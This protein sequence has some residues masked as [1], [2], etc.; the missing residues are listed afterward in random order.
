MKLAIMQPYFFPYIGYFQLI[1][2]VDKFIFY[3]D[4]NFIKK[5]WINRNNILINDSAFLFSIP[6][7]NI[8]QNKLINEV[9]LFFDS[10]EKER[11]LRRIELAYKKADE[12]D[13]F[14]PVLENFILNDSSVKISELAIN[15][16]ILVCEY[17]KLDVKFEY[18]SGTHSDS[19]SFEKEKRI[20]HI[21]NKEAADIY[22]NP[23]GGKELYS[24]EDFESKGLTLQ[25]I[26]SENIKYKQYHTS[27]VPWLSI[28]DVLMFNDIKESNK[29]I[30]QYKLI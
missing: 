4:V 6:C 8:S 9:D 12:F 2:A 23:I 1:H 11:F 15:S 17:L 27:F 22:I 24:K 10:N 28:I 13:N 18:S 7:K 29:F 14:F 5:G 26:E 19:I 3:D 20:Q 25:F 30:R 16:V 21:V